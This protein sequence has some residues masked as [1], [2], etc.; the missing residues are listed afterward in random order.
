MSGCISA[1]RETC[2]CDDCAAA[3]RR[4]AR[5]MMAANAPTMLPERKRRAATAA[6]KGVVAALFGRFTR[7]DTL[8]LGG[9]RILLSLP[10]VDLPLQFHARALLLRSLLVEVAL[11]RSPRRVANV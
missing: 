6:P 5:L 9:F 2:A 1:S 10:L 4:R 3:R 8:E 11:V 7:L